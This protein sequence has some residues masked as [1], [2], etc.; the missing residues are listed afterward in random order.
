MTVQCPECFEEYEVKDGIL[1][2]TCPYCNAELNVCPECGE[3][4]ED[5]SAHPE[6]PNCGHTDSSLVAQCPSCFVFVHSDTAHPS[7]K[8]RCPLCGSEI[9][10]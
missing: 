9:E 7:D 8:I 5:V 6:C 1:E 2:F 10:F 4:F 3:I